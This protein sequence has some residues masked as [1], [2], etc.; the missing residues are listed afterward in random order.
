MKHYVLER[1]LGEI[2]VTVDT[3]HTIIGLASVVSVVS[4]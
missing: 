4:I 3:L 2:L 1:A